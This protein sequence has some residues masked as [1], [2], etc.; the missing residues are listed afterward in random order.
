MQR[1]RKVESSSKTKWIPTQFQDT[2]SVN[3]L[4]KR[5]MITTVP[6]KTLFLV[7]PYI[8]TQSLRLKTKIKELFK[9]QLPSGKLEITFKSTQRMSSCFSFQDVIPRTSLSHVIY[10]YKCPRCNS[11]QIGSTFSYWEK[12]L[13]EHLHMSA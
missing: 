5:V 9:D 7:L 13:E 8:A 1:N 4:E 12:R 10:E 2:L 11:G 3:S 6:R